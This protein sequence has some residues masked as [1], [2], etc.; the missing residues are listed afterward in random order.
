MPKQPEPYKSF[1]VRLWW[2][3]EGGEQESGW[4]IEIESIQ[5]GQKWQIS[6]LETIVRFLKAQANV[7]LQII[8][9]NI[10]TP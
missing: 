6:D 3:D 10:P 7:N 2:E 1:L 5:T 4:R 8:K 9:Q